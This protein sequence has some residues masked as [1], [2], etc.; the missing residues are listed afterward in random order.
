MLRDDDMIDRTTA[1]G[2][3]SLID[4]TL[5]DEDM[6][7]EKGSTGYTAFEQDNFA[8]ILD[9]IKDQISMIG[10]DVRVL[11]Q[12][13]DQQ[14]ALINGILYGTPTPEI[15]NFFSLNK[16]WDS[17]QAFGSCQRHNLKRLADL[18][19]R[20]QRLSKSID[21]LEES[22][23]ITDDTIDIHQSDI[24]QLSKQ[25]IQTATSLRQY[26]SYVSDFEQETVKYKEAGQAC[27][28]R[29]EYVSQRLNRL[30]AE[31]YSP[32]PLILEEGE[33]ELP[34]SNTDI[35]SVSSP[36][37]TAAECPVTPDVSRKG[38]ASLGCAYPYV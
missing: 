2:P 12:D 1:S 27:D 28:Q 9:N 18:E 30:E 14:Q 37:T 32:D 35:D 11:Q 16:A 22:L 23:S 36:Q 38:S 31:I 25:Q 24:D 8:R 26:E 17:L 7:Y 34:L 3:P 13:R 6:D 20:Q 5:S 33:H 15:P 4:L 29:F 21:A 19:S 10:T